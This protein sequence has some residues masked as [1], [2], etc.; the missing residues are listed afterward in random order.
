MDINRTNYSQGIE[1]YPSSPKPLRSEDQMRS[2]LQITLTLLPL[3]FP[4]VLAAPTLVDSAKRDGTP[5]LLPVSATQAYSPY[6]HLAG[7]GYCLFSGSWNCGSELLPS[8][9]VSDAHYTA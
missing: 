4:A 7:A 8:L 3:L 2:L 1:I 9:F 5:T 6:A